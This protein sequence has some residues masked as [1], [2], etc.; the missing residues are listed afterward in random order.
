MTKKTISQP[1]LPDHMPLAA[2]YAPQLVKAITIPS[3]AEV[4]QAQAADPL[5]TKIVE[6]LQISNAAKH[7]PVFFTDNGLLY[8]QIIDIKQ[9]VIPAS[10]VDQTLRQF[11]GPKILNH[12]GSN[13]MLAAIKAHFWW[14]RME[15]N[16][17][18]PAVENINVADVGV[19]AALI[20]DDAPII[21]EDA[22]LPP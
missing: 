12:Q 20:V 22:D 5:I 21:G 15:E 18:I 14:P 16:V 2:N 10:M 17:V 8:P 7:P 19:L 4:K 9:L 1:T 11:Q 13:R 3:H 6:F